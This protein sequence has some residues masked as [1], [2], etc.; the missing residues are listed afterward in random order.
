MYHK[1]T[2]DTHSLVPFLS[3]APVIDWREDFLLQHKFKIFNSWNGVC[4]KRYKLAVYYYE[5]NG[6]Y[7]CLYELEK[8]PNELVNLSSN[9]E[10][11]NV[12]Q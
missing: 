11:A 6:P 1:S 3:D 8:D 7:E 5:L 4:S 2:K 12:H 10:Y 9:P